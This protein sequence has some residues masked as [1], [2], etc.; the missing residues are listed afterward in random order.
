MF[1]RQLFFLTSEQLCA[2]Q[3]RS[4][5]LSDGVCFAADSAGVDAFMDYLDRYESHPAYLLADLVEEDFQ[6]QLL[7]HVGGKAG[8]KLVERRLAQH[9]R[10]TPFRHASI[11]GRSDEGR[12]DDIALFSALTNPALLQPWLEA[13]EWMKVPLAGIYSTTLLSPSL[14][15]RLQLEQPHLLLVTQQSGGLRQ[16]YFQDGQLKFSRLT[17]AIDRDGV[18]VN[19]P[20]ET[21]KTQQFLTSTRL[22]GRGDVLHTVIV[23]PDEQIARLSPL[24]ADGQETAYEFVS[25][26]AAAARA[27]LADAPPLADRLLLQLLGRSQPPSHYPAGPQGRYYQLWRARLA[28]YASSA[29][30]AAVGVLWVGGNLWSY[31]EAQGRSGALQVETARYEASYRASMSTMP[32]VVAPTANMKA[33]V[34][35]ERMVSEQGPAPLD[36]MGIVSAALD[37]APRVRL[38][39]LGWRAG[40]DGGDAATAAAATTAT[41]L[42]GS[43]SGFGGGAAAAGQEPISSLLVGIPVRPP[44]TLRIEAE[45]VAARNDYR[46]VLDSMN[47]FAQ[48]L[49]RHPRMTVEIEQPALDVR[50]S[51]KLSGKAGDS[52]AGQPASFILNLR[53]NP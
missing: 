16:T 50:P 2:Y 3:W 48:L 42:G 15:T 47:Q 36:M 37:Q 4:G 20:A 8:R 23:A 33:A 35:I 21:E 39:R 24:C 6:R 32:P 14:V 25:M 17:P 11:Q 28:M 30:I 27:G 46:N 18:A 13:V 34:T 29:A 41:G 51:V 26:A 22:L 12:R 10:E 49:A 5:T 9:Y 19:L 38:T 7:P 45:V 40:A 31:A 44:Q 43:G 52:E 1:H 53:W